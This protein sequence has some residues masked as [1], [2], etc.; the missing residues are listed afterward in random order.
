M[1]INQSKNMLSGSSFFE[2]FSSPERK[3]QISNFL[4]NIA[5]SQK[6]LYLR[7]LI[8]YRFIFRLIRLNLV[9]Y[10]FRLCPEWP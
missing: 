6:L 3:L 8:F 5:Y 10:F 9:S 1:Q 7:L 4:P 2:K